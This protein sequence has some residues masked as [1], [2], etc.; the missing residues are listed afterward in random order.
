MYDKMDSPT[1][2]GEH[3]ALRKAI[4]QTLERQKGV[5]FACPA[6]VCRGIYAG[7][8]IIAPNRDFTP[9]TMDSRGYVPVEWWI[10]SKAHAENPLPKENEGVTSL[11]IEDQLVHFPRAIEVAEDILLGEYN[12][13]WPLTKVLD[14]GGPSRLPKY[15]TPTADIAEAE[16]PPIPC[17]IHAGM[18]VNGSCC[19][20]GKTE[21]YFF[22]PLDLPPY[23]LHLPVIKTRLGLKPTTTKSEFLESLKQF[24]KNDDVY[25]L[26]NEFEIR[27]WET[28]AIEEKTVHAPG[29]WLTF[30]VQ[31]PQDDCNLLS[32][33]F[34]QQIPND[35]LQ[36][37]KQD[38]QLRGLADEEALMANTMD[39]ERNVDPRFKENWWHKCETLEEG[40]WGRKIRT[41]YYIFYGEGLIIHPGQS[42]TRGADVRP[43][44]GFVWSGEGDVNCLPLQCSDNNKRE[45][46]VTPHHPASFTNTSSKHDLMIF[47]VFPMDLKQ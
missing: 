1:L 35:E 26:M 11:F 5:V 15:S 40:S 23:N 6:F 12:Q 38:N 47:T 28:W 31:R 19:G 27:P 13:C 20:H 37:V 9:D 39:W 44:A 21:S 7:R 24:G 43:F 34:G 8:G 41:F 18:V 42:Y 36:L 25:S 22:P 33:Q 46:L 45:F 14:I 16:V 10:M 17:H 30:E 32:W 29:P 4:V 3:S 2:D